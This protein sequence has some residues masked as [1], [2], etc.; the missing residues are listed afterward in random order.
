MTAEPALQ[1]ERARLVRHLRASGAAVDPRVLAAFLAAPRHEF[2]PGAERGAA[3]DDRAL[4]IGYGQTISQP[5][6]IA[7]ML[8]A[9]ALEPA[10]KVLEVGSGSGYA[11]LLL[12]MLCR[13][14]H[15]IELLPELAERAR[16]TLASLGV[17]NVAIHT[18]NGY[19]GL[20]EHAPYDA[21][22]VSAAPD[23]VPSALLEQLAPAGRIAIPV[24]DQARQVLRVGVRNG[25]HSVT[26]RDDIPCLF[27]PL[28]HGESG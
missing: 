5:S 12:G 2:V 26:F 15:G 27:V 24:G 25:P 18:G 19:R 11:A 16:R 21:I 23:Q 8:E 6:M 20:P 13:E 4:P 14:V 28:V 3:Y 9:L 22:L 7:V 1:A 17:T 10:D